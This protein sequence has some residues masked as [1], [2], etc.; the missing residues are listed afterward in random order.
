MAPCSLSTI[1][2]LS[3][4][5]ELSTAHLTF[6]HPSTLL[7]VMNNVPHRFNAELTNPSECYEAFQIMRDEV[8]V[9]LLLAKEMPERSI[10]TW[11]ILL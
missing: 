11:L 6:P 5:V 1:Y 9:Y 7:L 10:N 8:L 3:M 2:A 4:M